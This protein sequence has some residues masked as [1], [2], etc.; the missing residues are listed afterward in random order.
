MEPKKRRKILYIITKSNLGGAQRYVYDIATNLPNDEFEPVVALGGNGPLREK[1]KLAGIETIHIP[2]LERDLGIFKELPAFVAITQIIWKLKPEIVHLNS[3]KA[4]GLGALAARMCN[5]LIRLSHLLNPKH[6][7]LNPSRII[8]TAHGWAF[9]EKRGT[10]VKKIIEYSSWL[11]IF[12][13]HKTIVVSADDMEKVKNFLFVQPKIKLIHNGIGKQ[14]FL[15]K[16]EA[17]K[18]IAEKI[19]QRLND[20]E[21]WIGTVAELH[22]N[23]G[24]EY[25]ITAIKTIT[26]ESTGNQQ[27][28]IGNPAYVIIGGGEERKNLEK[29]TSENNLTNTV[30]FTGEYP[31]GSELLKAFDLF[32][33]PSLKEGLPYSV[34]ESGSAGLPTIATNVGGVSEVIEDMK[35]GIVIKARRPKEISDAITFLFAHKEKMEEFGNQLKKTVEEKYTLERMIKETVSLYRS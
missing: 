8:F 6:Y 11:T 18:I 34:L 25:A 5:F 29:I 27:N 22:K 31:D 23:K 13:C 3:S 32:I 2:F 24:L 35:S 10:V 14:T 1:L 26:Q 33:L 30:F 16:T 7:T 19:G 28:N 4:G 21:F 15:E 20:K 9:K 17:R 12:L